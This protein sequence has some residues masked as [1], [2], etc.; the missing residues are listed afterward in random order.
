MKLCLFTHADED[1][2]SIAIIISILKAYL[3]SVL[4]GGAGG[5]ASLE[6]QRAV[7]A[8]TCTHSYPTYCMNCFQQLKLLMVMNTCWHCHAL[9]L[10]LEIWWALMC[11]ALL[12][13]LLECANVCDR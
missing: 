9:D 11:S 10:G 2:I 1:F 3:I 6:V 5:K 8:D 4:F 12:R 7:L 13:S